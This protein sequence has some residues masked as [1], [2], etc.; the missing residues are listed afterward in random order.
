MFVKST[1]D[2]LYYAERELEKLTRI[3]S[4]I[5]KLHKAKLSGNLTEIDRMIR[6]L[7]KELPK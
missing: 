3:Y 1:E 4:K 7:Y 5:K 2:K 6:L